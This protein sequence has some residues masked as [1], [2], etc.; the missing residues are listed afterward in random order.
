MSRVGRLICQSP[1]VIIWTVHTYSTSKQQVHTILFKKNSI[2]QQF[3]ISKIV[4]QT[5]PTPPLHVSVRKIK[6][7]TKTTVEHEKKGA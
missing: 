6:I 2:E 3:G 1:G 4:T 7:K 5:D